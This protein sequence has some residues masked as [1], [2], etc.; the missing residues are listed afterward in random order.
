MQEDQQNVDLFEMPFEE[1]DELDAAGAISAGEGPRLQEAAAGGAISA[2]G[3]QYGKAGQ[4]AVD[5]PQRPSIEHRIQIESG[6]P[7]GQG[8]HESR[9][10]DERDG[11]P[12]PPQSEK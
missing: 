7:T 10:D 4:K 11:V 3:G 12:M 5:Q 9:L 6:W 8:A 2:S 1:E